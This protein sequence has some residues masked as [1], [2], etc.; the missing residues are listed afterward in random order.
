MTIDW[1]KVSDRIRGLIGVHEERDLSRVAERL[2]VDETSLRRI[3]SRDPRKPEFG[4][5][6]AIVRVFGLDPTWVL[7]GRYDPSTHRV[8]LNCDTGEIAVA[9]NR[10]AAAD[11]RGGEA[12]PNNA[13][14][15]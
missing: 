11:A 2:D 8:A 3:V 7:T 15:W 1:T 13:D 6:A 14:A 10:I 5:I 12:R 4:A 9:L